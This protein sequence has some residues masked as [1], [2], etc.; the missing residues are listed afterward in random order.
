FSYPGYSEAL[1]GFPD[2]R[3]DSNDKK[4]NPNE[5]VVEW[6]SRKSAFKGQAAAFGAWDVFPYI[7]NVERSG[8]LVNAGY[9]PFTALPGSTVIESLNLLK[10]E[11]D[12]LDGEA[13][14]AFTFHTALEYFK[15]K[16]PRVLFL[17]LGETDEW[18][19]A[20]RYDLYLRAAHRFDQY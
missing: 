10:R 17:S 7:F 6:L 20:G 12:V 15:V 16:K 9:D 8:L 18:A 19:H 5:N 13:L 3:I 2:P 1:C 14:D 11:T 4:P